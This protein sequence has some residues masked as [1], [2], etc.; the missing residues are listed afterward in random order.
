MTEPIEDGVIYP[1][2]PDRGWRRV[3]CMAMLIGGAVVLIAGLV[4]AFSFGGD[5]DEADALCEDLQIQLTYLDAAAADQTARD[6]VLQQMD[7][8]GCE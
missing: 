4:A 3:G 2:R 5:T 6:D 8:A 7:D 1:S